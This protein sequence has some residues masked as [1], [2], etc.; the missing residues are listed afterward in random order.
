MTSCCS[1]CPKPHWQQH[2]S[3]VKLSTW[4]KLGRICWSYK[5]N[6]EDLWAHPATNFVCVRA[7]SNARVLQ[8]RHPASTSVPNPKKHNTH[9]SPSF[10]SIECCPL[11]SWLQSTLT[12]ERRENIEGGS[13]P[14]ILISI[15][16]LLL[17][18]GLWWK[19]VFTDYEQLFYPTQILK[20][21]KVKNKYVISKLSILLKL[22]SL[23]LK[24]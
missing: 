10:G 3:L 17:V 20:P 11:V 23:G 15:A 12:E 1:Q 16:V 2:C 13:A 7:E 24:R 22:Q 8:K 5:E 18:R 9:Y 19:E 14:G 4:H 21:Q 6:W